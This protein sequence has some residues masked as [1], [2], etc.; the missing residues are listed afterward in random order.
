MTLTMKARFLTLALTAVMVIS[1]TTSRAA[2]RKK[3]AGTDP[4]ELPL[5]PGSAVW[6]VTPS[7]ST[8]D[9]ARKILEETKW[10]GKDWR[11]GFPASGGKSVVAVVVR[12][13][14]LNPLASSY[15]KLSDLARAA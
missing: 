15:E 9:A 12:S 11:L 6:L 13:S 8:V 1:S 3:I 10:L 7:P 4:I 5:K 2:G 14:L